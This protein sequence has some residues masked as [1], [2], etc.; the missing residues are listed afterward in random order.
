MKL[1]ETKINPG[2]VFRCC[3]QAVLGLPEDID[4][5][6][7]HVVECPHC[8]GGTMTLQDGVWRGPLAVKK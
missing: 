6:E 8:T 7:G 5:E 4:F 2:G 1:M 3:V